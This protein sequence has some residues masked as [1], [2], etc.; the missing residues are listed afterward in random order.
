ML[1]APAELIQRYA[2]YLYEDII[3]EKRTFVNINIVA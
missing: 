1:E 3:K 2:H